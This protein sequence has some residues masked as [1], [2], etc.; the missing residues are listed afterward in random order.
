M[1]VITAKNLNVPAP[2]A[3]YMQQLRR[4]LAAFAGPRDPL[5]VALST[6][7]WP[8]RQAMHAIYSVGLSTIV[9]P[10]GLARVDKP[11]CWRFLAGG[12]K[13]MTTADGCWATHDAYRSPAK[14][15]TTFRGPEAADVLTSAEQLNNLSELTT[16]PENQYELWVLRIPGLYLE[17]FWLKS[18]TAG[19]LI[20]PYGL[21]TDINNNVAVR[22]V[23]PLIKGRAYVVADFQQ[24]VGRAAQ[25]RLAAHVAA[26]PQ[27][28]QTW[29][30]GQCA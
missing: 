10:N 2:S 13:T 23:E 26:P 4:S 5:T 19:D 3:E 9:D 15:M 28:G 11:F 16:H 12:H 21:V 18:G 29:A 1:E 22:G 24:I 7:N 30:A 14:V 27:R 17:A 20:V 6:M 25:Q 8:G